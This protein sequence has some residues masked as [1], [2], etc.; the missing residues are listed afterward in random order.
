LE[1]V[2]SWIR[3]SPF[4]RGKDPL[5]HMLLALS[6]EAEAAG[7]PLTDAEKKILAAEAV[8]ERPVPNDLKERIKPLIFAI[9]QRER[10]ADPAT[11]TIGF[12]D[13]LEWVE[14]D[15]PNIAALAEEFITSGEFG[16]HP[17]FHGEGLFKD[18][19]QLVG[20]A[21][22]LVVALMAIVVVISLLFDR[23]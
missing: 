1:E 4:G 18:L 5:E 6:R 23:R 14:P 17:Q 15:Y 22:A 20:C 3:K 12:G 13:A 10:T 19:A 9:L 16:A 8:P 7:A 21:I 11:S 2:M